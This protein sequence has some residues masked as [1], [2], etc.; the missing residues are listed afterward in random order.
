MTIVKTISEGD[1]GLTFTTYQFRIKQQ[2]IALANLQTHI[3][4]NYYVRC[5]AVI[6]LQ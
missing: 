4:D 1:T 2:C 3:C 5:N 6:S